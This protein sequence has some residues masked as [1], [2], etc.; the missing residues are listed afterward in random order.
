MPAGGHQFDMFEANVDQM[1]C[2]VFRAANDVL[3]VFG[4]CADTWK[5]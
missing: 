4:Q 1:G 5:P 3:A 2:N